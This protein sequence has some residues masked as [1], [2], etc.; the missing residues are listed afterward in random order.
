MAVLSSDTLDPVRD[1]DPITM[2]FGRT[3]EE[4]S[5]LFS[6][7]TQR[8]VNHDGVYDLL[9]DFDLAAAGFLPE[10]T[11]GC[12]KVLGKDRKPWFGKDTIRVR[13]ATSEN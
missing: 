3:G 1:L 6:C 11:V 13:R 5:G 7:V 10:D 2:S 8:D 12:L 4:P 9:C